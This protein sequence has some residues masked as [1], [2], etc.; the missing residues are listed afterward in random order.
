MTQDHSV[1]KAEI[2]TIEQNIVLHGTLVYQTSPTLKLSK[3]GLS[4]RVKVLLKKNI[5]GTS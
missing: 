1:V 5:L 2:S 3:S 4:Q